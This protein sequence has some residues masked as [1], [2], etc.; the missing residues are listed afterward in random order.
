MD[1]HYKQEV[2]VGLLVIASTALFAAG[3]AWLSG[4][5]IG[6]ADTVDVPVQFSDVLGLRAGDPVQTSGVKVGNVDRV[7][8]ED[9]GRVIVYLTVNADSRPHTDA[10]AQVAALDFLGAKYINYSPGKGPQLLAEKQSITG[11]RELGLAEGAAGLAQRATEAIASAQ[12]IF[13]ERTAEDIHNTMTAATRALDMVTKLG[14]GPQL[15]Q[16]SEAVRALQII[17][18]RLDSILSNPS[19][20]NSVDQ[21]DELTGSLTEMS[22]GLRTTGQTLQTILKRVE[23]GKGTLGKAAVDTMLYHNLNQTMVK[24]QA[25]LDDV[26]NN[27][28]R[29]INVK[30]F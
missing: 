26:K 12:K 20:R 17:A 23:E 6:P 18:T 15:Q 11:E 10:R 4:K 27:P 22:Q 13:N 7:V 21:L 2:S 14:T 1:L 8:L 19:I 9:V 30:V 5:R 29:Y 3:L 16:A 24:M 28:G 25:L